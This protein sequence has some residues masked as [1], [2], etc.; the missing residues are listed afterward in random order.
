MEAHV[1]VAKTGTSQ[2]ALQL[3]SEGLSFIIRQPV[4]DIEEISIE[5]FCCFDEVNNL[6]S[7]RGRRDIILFID[8]L[9]LCRFNRG[10][11]DA[12]DI[13]EQDDCRRMILAFDARCEE[14][15]QD[16]IIHAVVGH[17]HGFL[18]PVVVQQKPCRSK[19]T[20]RLPDVGRFD[21]VAGGDQLERLVFMQFFQKTLFCQNT[22][23]LP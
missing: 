23:P 21:L 19:E 6:I 9:G 2:K 20:L 14:E 10:A 1:A 11:V 3:L 7:D 22:T 15:C 4:N 8:P 5:R 17:R 16:G 13:F 18:E 12:K